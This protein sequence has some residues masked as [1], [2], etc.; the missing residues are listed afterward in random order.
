MK[1]ANKIQPLTLTIILVLLAQNVFGQTPIPVKFIDSYAKKHDFSGTI[2]I[3]KNFNP[4]YAR[5]F[6]LANRPHKVPNRIETKY[7]IA[8]I[9]KAFTAILILRLVEQGKIDLNKT[10]KTYLPDYAGE[11]G[12]RATVHQL[13]NHTAGMAN[14]DRKL[15]SVEA[16]IKNG[17]PHYQTPLTT[18]E[19][20]SRYASESLVNAPGKTFDY[21]NADYI[22]LGKIIERICGKPYELV[23]EENILNPLQMTNSGLLRQ[24]DMPANLADTYFYRDD[25]KRLANDLPVY[26][27]NWYAAGAMYSTAG[28]VLKFADALFAGKL[29]G[30]ETLERMFTP[31]LGE[32]G[33]GVWIYRDYEINGKKYTIVKRP[34][35]IMGANSMLFH[36]LEP[37]ATIIILSN[38]NAASLDEFAAEIGKRL[39]N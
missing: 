3:R 23:L 29:L 15:T 14:I 24:A 8:S 5:S 17:M 4:L 7:K 31:G 32:Y 36:I 34:G 20:L 10:I 35:S 25:L 37:G 33:Y 16:A 6:G 19:L 13:L 12:D 22:V 1:P 30:K 27:E 9:T 2:L 11:A 26:I 38:T 21:N 39:M 28:D 18:D